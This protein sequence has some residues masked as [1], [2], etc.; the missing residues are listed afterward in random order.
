MKMNMGKRVLLLVLSCSVLTFFI[1]S[2]FSSYGMFRIREALNERGQ[3]MVENAAD[4]GAEIAERQTGKFLLDAT[5]EKADFIDQLITARADSKHTGELEDIGRRLSEDGAAE[6]EASFLLDQQGTI[7]LIFQ[8]QYGKQVI[9]QGENLLQGRNPDVTGAVRRMIAG[10]QDVLTVEMDGRG[11]FL[12]FSPVKSAGWSYG[13]LMEKEPVTAPMTATRTKLWQGLEHFRDSMDELYQGLMIGALV[14]WVLLLAAFLQYSFLVSRRF[15]EPIHQLT[16]GVK[17]I[18]RGNL[19]QQIEVNTGD[20]LEHLSVCFNAMSHELK[21]YM[22]NLTAATEEKERI[23]AELNVAA[24]IQVGMLPGDFSVFSRNLAGD[25]YAVMQPAKEVGGDFYDFYLQDER[26]LVLTIA[27]V[28]GKGI[29]AALFMVTAKT[30]LKNY[31]AVMNS[32]GDV[33]GV[34][35]CANDQLC[36]NNEEDMFVT[37]FTG[38]LDLVTGAFVYVNGGHNPPLVGRLQ[39]DGSRLFDYIQMKKGRVLGLRENLEFPSM[40]LELHP[41]DMIFLYT[42]GVTEA[43]NEA[44]E[45][46]SEARLQT[47]LNRAPGNASAEEILAFLQEDIRAYVGNAEPSDDITMMC[48]LYQG[49]EQETLHEVQPYEK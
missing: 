1:L 32:P 2:M 29:P 35:A 6:E 10:E 12:A 18:A 24:E 49:T 39:P 5:H 9:L 44:Q 14:L 19:D 11:Y 23:A 30:V 13:T 26:H 27:D 43:L 37:V 46:Y 41:G 38:I 20:E 31:T 17:E 45:L 33:S 15:A 40:Q 25:I 4:H 36:R 3:E 22:A 8:E 47:A 16:A 21:D 42:D 7:L 28:S 34:M 48:F